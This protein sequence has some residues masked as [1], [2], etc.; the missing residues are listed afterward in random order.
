MIAVSNDF[1]NAMKQPIKEID[2]YIMG[3]VTIKS[4]DNLISF[5]ISCDSGM[6]KS[7]MRKLEAKYL[8][9]HNLLGQWVHVGYGVKLPA[10]TFEYLD[11]GSFLVTEIT[12]V[13]D[14]GVT[15]IVGYDK[16]VSSMREYTKLD[17][18][19]P[20][21]LKDYTRLL[22]EACG[23]ELGNDIFGKNLLNEKTGNSTNTYFYSNSGFTIKAGVTYTLSCD[24]KCAGIYVIKK[25]DKTNLFMAYSSTALTFTPTEDTVV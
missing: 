10:G 1:K 13:K 19:Y 21:K 18:E 14:T 17:A 2:A 20:V 4:E 24:T 11:Y 15:T 8:G 7:A 9:E 3:D 25:D 22:C 23:L 16:M 12:T 6:C 5:K